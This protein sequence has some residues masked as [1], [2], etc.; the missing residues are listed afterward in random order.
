MTAFGLVLAFRDEDTSLAILFA[1]V[2]ASGGIAGWSLWHQKRWAKAAFLIWSVVATGS[3]AAVGWLFK[4]ASIEIVLG[5]L[6]FGIMWLF[7]TPYVRH[8][9]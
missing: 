2:V 5:A 7:L 6:A 3:G 8:N 4:D 9:A 1:L